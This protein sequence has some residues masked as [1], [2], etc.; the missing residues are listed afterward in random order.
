LTKGYLLLIIK[1]EFEEKSDKLYGNQR[2]F[3]FLNN[4]IPI[5]TLNIDRSA[6]RK[7][8]EIDSL[9]QKLKE[10]KK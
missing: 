2:V 9:I 5:S 7:Y 8:P 10:F 6:W 4:S 3:N 1:I